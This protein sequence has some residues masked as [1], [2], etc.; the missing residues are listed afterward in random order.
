MTSVAFY[1]EQ[2]RDGADEAE[3][4]F[5][6]LQSTSQNV[7]KNGPVEVAE[8]QV[9]M[10]PSGSESNDEVL[11]MLANAQG[12]AV[13]DLRTG[14]YRHEETPERMVAL[15]NVVMQADSMNL[16]QLT[17]W[18]MADRAEKNLDVVQILLKQVPRLKAEQQ[19]R[20]KAR[21][22]V[23]NQAAA[24]QDAEQQAKN[25]QFQSEFQKFKEDIR[26][27]SMAPGDGNG[28]DKIVRKAMDEAPKQKTFVETALVE[29]YKQ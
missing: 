3:W 2:E 16:T 1:I 23:Q 14:I 27:Q 12:L 5:N 4:F 21:Q 19:A 10:N 11:A 25:A 17:Q 15:A 18:L 9:Y 22:V 28:Q 13:E 26:V 24:A 6:Y 8:A 7:P 20:R 29:I